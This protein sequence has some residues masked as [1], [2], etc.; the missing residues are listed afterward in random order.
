MLLA[1]ISQLGKFSN[2]HLA[3]LAL[4]TGSAIMLYRSNVKVESPP[5]LLLDLAKLKQILVGGYRLISKLI[6]FGM[7]GKSTADNLA[8]S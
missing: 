8:K 4:R 3:E 2:F 6:I 7:L 1:I 5:L